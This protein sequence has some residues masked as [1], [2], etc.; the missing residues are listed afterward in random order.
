MVIQLV[1][2][3]LIGECKLLER[4]IT[5]TVK[6]KKDL[7]RQFI[8]NN[9]DPSIIVDAFECKKETFGKERK[10]PTLYLMPLPSPLC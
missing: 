2:S 6:I 3:T 4:I 5:N 7:K 10:T 1:P 8:F 9:K